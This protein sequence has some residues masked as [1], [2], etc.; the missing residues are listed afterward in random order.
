MMK[1]LELR[2]WIRL[3]YQR[4]QLIINPASKFA[5]AFVVFH[6]LNASIGYDDRFARFEVE[7]LLSLFC[8]FVPSSIMVLFAMLLSIVH[9]Y[10]DSVILAALVLIIFIIMYCFLYRYAPAYGYAAV[11]IPILYAFDMP[12]IIPI[13]LG[14]VTNP[15]AILPTACG[16]IVHYVLKLVR[17]DAAFAKITELNFEDVQLVFTT[18]ID[19]FLANRQMFLAVTIF[20]LIILVVFVVRSMKIKYSFEISIVSGAVMCIL[21]FLFGYLKIGISNEIFNMII[22]TIASAMFAFAMLFMKRI[23]DYTAIEKVQFEDDA[24]YY[25]VKAIPKIEIS[26]PNRKVKRIGRQEDEDDYDEDE[27]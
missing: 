22:G 4:L 20:S 23:L 18:A 7:F 24:Y 12:F 25:Y 26:I 1:L 2:A 10:A 8:S 11:V 19:K 9:I 17:E 3:I 15:I 6:S 27:E 16:V 21:G 5:M 13:Y 14:L